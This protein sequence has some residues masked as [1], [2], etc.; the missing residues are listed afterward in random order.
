MEEL[1]KKIKKSE[2]ERVSTINEQ[3]EELKKMREQKNT[4]K[5]RL[6]SLE[7]AYDTER[8]DWQET[9]EIN[10]K[11]AN[12]LELKLVEMERM[13][14]ADDE[15]ARRESKELRLAL[16]REKSCARLLAEQKT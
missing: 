16:E 7:K 9:S 14:G 10:R 13:K 6:R 1:L 2:V 8:G 15:H 11:R 12:E 3:E 4:Y 5:V